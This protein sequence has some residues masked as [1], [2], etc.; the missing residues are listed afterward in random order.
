MV[1]HLTYNDKIGILDPEGINPNP[2][3]NQPYSDEYK[4]LAKIWSK[5]PTYEKAKEI[6]VALEE[7]QLIF[8]ISATGS[9]KSVI[10]PKLTLHYTNYRG[11]IGMTLPKRVITLSAATFATRTL[12]ITLGKEIGY[13]YKGSP[14]EMSNN[15]KILYMTDGTLITKFTK[16]PLL[17]E[18]KVIILDEAHE[19]NSRTDLILLL[20]KNLLQSGKRPDLKVLIMSATINTTVYQDYFSDIPNKIIE[21]AGQPNYP[22]TVHFLDEPTNFYLDKGLEI[23]EML[24]QDA[25]REDMLFFITTSNEAVQLCREMREKYP[26]VYCIEVY[27]D[28]DKN[29]KIY[30]ESKDKYL[31]LGNYDQKLI[32]A[33]N[34]AESS[35]TIAGLKCVI[36][37]GYELYSYYDPD[38][39]GEV[40]E[41]RLISRAQAL[42][43]RGRVGR[44]SP[45]SCYHLL[46]RAQFDLLKEY[47]IPDI[48]KHDITIDL[49]KIIQITPNKTYSEGIKMLNELIDRPKKE[50]IA[51]AKRLYDMY[52]II[53]NDKLTKIGEIITQFSALQLNRILFLYYAYQLQC[54]KEA[55]IIIGMA[56]ALNGK[57]TNLFFKADTICES[58]C[59]KP[60]ADILMKKLAQKKGDHFTYL[61][62][63]QEYKKITEKDAWIRKYG[64]RRDVL[65]NADKLSKAYYSKILRIFKPVE[66]ARISATNIKKNLVEALKRSHLHLTAKNM[67][68]IST[69]KHIEGQINRNSALFYHY[70]KKDLAK[71]KFIYDELTNINGNWEFNIITLIS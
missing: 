21:I 54:A 65:N 13:R 66:M 25:T 30:A 5:F 26:R 14:K 41:K 40:L 33:T 59:E 24:V 61:T 48:L 49:I 27:A 64:I 69:T 47:P 50:Y 70:H 36:D 38:V 63:Y 35:L 32:M 57:L 4:E 23:I 71:K 34:V 51:S 28:M 31:E 39:Y 55:S 18:F 15:N 58:G 1:D 3:T 12:D 16:D 2:L 19:R 29:M 6:L 43:R 46:T 11:K 68:P 10:V 67:S 60:I 56:E 53:D 44:T 17:L 20:L 37:S 7:Y 45:G 42:Q 8:I 22:I 9:G 52:Q 62:F